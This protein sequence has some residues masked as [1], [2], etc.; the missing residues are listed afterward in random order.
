MLLISISINPLVT[1][2]LPQL[3]S[4]MKIS[5]RDVFNIKL[6]YLYIFFIFGY[7]PCFYSLKRK[8]FFSNFYLSLWYFLT[9]LIKFLFALLCTFIQL[10]ISD[11]KLEDILSVLLVTI[12]NILFQIIMLT[13][14]IELVKNH[15]KMC[16][17][18]S[19]LSV[20]IKT[21]GRQSRSKS[22][23]RSL[24][25]KSVLNV[26]LI[27]VVLIFVGEAYGADVAYFTVTFINTINYVLFIDFFYLAYGLL[28]GLIQREILE[29]KSKIKFFNNTVDGN[30][31]KISNRLAIVIEIKENINKVFEKSLLFIFGYRLMSYIGLVSNRSFYY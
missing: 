21:S 7:L 18:A 25:L 3:V 26:F 15:R 23:E 13:F 17:I 1:F 20:L 2:L 16:H 19:Q 31:T 27:I 14:T 12:Q 28:K 24:V 29:I 4:A 11:K 10:Q 6:F 30:I 22:F 9:N 5:S 8:K